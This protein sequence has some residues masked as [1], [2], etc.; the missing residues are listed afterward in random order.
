M[1]DYDTAKK[2]DAKDDHRCFGNGEC[3]CGICVCNVGW[4]GAECSQLDLLPAKTKAHSFYKSQNKNLRGMN[5]ENP[6]WGGAAWFEDGKWKFLAGGK[7]L[8]NSEPKFN[9][10]TDWGRTPAYSLKWQTNGKENPWDYGVDDQKNPFKLSPTGDQQFKFVD[11]NKEK[12]E[13]TSWLTLFESEGID[14]EGPYKKPTVSKWFKAF[15]ADFKQYGS[16]L[17]CLS[18]AGGGFTI[19]ESPSG[20]VDGDWTDKDGQPLDKLWFG[21]T[22]G[23][24][25]DVSTKMPTPVY[26][27][28]ENGHCDKNGK[29]IDSKTKQERDCDNN[30]MAAWNCHAAD[31][32]LLVHKNLTEPHTV[33]IA[34][35]GTRCDKV[36]HVERLGLLISH[37]GW[38]GP[39][40]QR[41]G[42]QIL[43]DGEFKNGGLE[44]LF[45][46]LDDRGTHMV[47]HTQAMDHTYNTQWVKPDSE[48]AGFHHKKKRGAYL[49]SADGAVRWSLSDWELFPSEIR[50]DD[51]STQF[52]LKQQRPSLIFNSKMQPTHLVT[53]VDFLYDPCCDWYGFG[54][55]WTLIQPIVTDC[56]AGQV[57]Q[58]GTCT[59]CAN[60]P[61]KYEG[62]CIQ[63]TTKYGECVCAAC[64]GGF[65]GD[66]CKVAPPRAVVCENFASA[67]QCGDMSAPEEKFDAESV[68]SGTCKKECET[69]A[70]QLGKEGCCFQFTKDPNK[71][72]RFFPGK[73]PKKAGNANSKEAAACSFR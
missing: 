24:D 41:P 60:G 61:S 14:V 72:C 55:A 53:G 1:L 52:L 25:P 69:K 38:K 33:V 71:N 12:Y 6:T 37:N 2:C 56:R 73:D 26:K 57:M 63:T 20:R 7:I 64:S 67:M 23:K 49:F 40:E 42:G 46:W 51:G 50:W 54:S 39:Y 59:T 19:L 45:M 18:N 27:F 22:E 35:R 8:K 4:R 10:I 9:P 36:D 3:V 70:Q 15:R 29:T 44:D 43:K 62:R 66:D 28:K 21:K 16:S 65:T 13:K 31:P 68:N 5:S 11:P 30:E 58:G 32:A 47:V 17:L 48:K 34:Y